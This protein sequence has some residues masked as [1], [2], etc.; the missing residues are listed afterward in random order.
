M[1]LIIFKDKRDDLAKRQEDLG[2]TIGSLR[3]NLDDATRTLNGRR[4]ISI[5][6]SEQ[7]TKL[8]QQHNLRLADYE[9][10]I[11]QMK[12]YDFKKLLFLVLLI[13]KCV[14]IAISQANLCV[15]TR[16]QRK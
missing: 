2:E 14:L 5:G 11:S 8:K 10:E 13:R 6:R 16:N 7:L 3:L 15:G 9:K 1:N 12:E 4:E